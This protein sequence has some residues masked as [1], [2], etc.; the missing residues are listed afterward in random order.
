MQAITLFEGVVLRRSSGGKA[1]LEAG[2]HR[3]AG[4]G[5]RAGRLICP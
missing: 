3:A 2:V 4:Q 1:P 5:R